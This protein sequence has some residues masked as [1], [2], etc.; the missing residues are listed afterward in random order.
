M[1]SHAVVV[2]TGS[3]GDLFPFLKLAL[4]LRDAGHA[5]TFVGPQLHAQTVQ[6]AGLPFH[7]TF[8]DPAVLDDPDVWHPTRGFGVV[9]RAVRPGLREL[10][11]IVA[12]LPED[13]PCVIVTHPLALHEALLCRALRPD[14]RVVLGYLAP[15]NIPT[16]YDP[17]LLG[18]LRVP[19][20]VPL[21]A[22][23]WLWRQIGARL[24]D[25]VVMPDINA[26]RAA[27]GVAPAKSLL[28]LLH[29]GPDLSV[30]LF[31]PWF[32][33]P[34]PDWPQPLC[35]GDFA[36]FDPDPEAEFTPELAQFLAAGEAPLVFTP[37][38]ANRQADAYFGHA[39]AAARALGKRA[40]FLT[41]HRD[42]VAAHL[43]PGV[44]W[45][46]YLPLRKILPHAAALIHHG[47]IGTTAEALRAG[48]PQLI[49][50]LAYDQF[51]NAERV[52]GL[53]VG[54]G[55]TRARLTTTKLTAH[56]R[57][58]LASRRLAERCKTVS[59]QF[60]AYEG[61]QTMLISISKTIS[62]TSK[63]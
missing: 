34:K 16:V 50:A 1:T 46:S 48:I 43:P 17:L 28:D 13:E 59:A 52:S 24:I 54:L 53:G 62:K 45:Q 10:G 60:D 36:L 20:W 14:L 29:D 33:E 22:R 9:W 61:W 8:A 49:V 47:G 23:R 44:L 41:P 18:P 56:L 21:A 58:L 40:I 4:G 63:N 30:T 38:T 3:A 12:A 42:Q 32:G 31:P 6:Q 5:I 35:C 27:A 26:D 37:G 19:R 15:S 7:G 25:P 55:L 39:L 11:D 51:D 2:T 57:A